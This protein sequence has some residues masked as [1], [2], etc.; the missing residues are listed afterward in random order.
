M[1][2]PYFSPNSSRRTPLTSARSSKGVCWGMTSVKR[3]LLGAVAILAVMLLAV[4]APVMAEHGTAGPAV[5]PSPQDFPGGEPN[6][7]AG[8][9]GIRFG[10]ADDDEQLED[11]A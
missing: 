11:G 10:G 1:I 5:T 8:T 6:C 9:T 7:P 3:S 2:R 4:A